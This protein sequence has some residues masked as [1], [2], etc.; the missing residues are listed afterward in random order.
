MPWTLTVRSG[1]QV[2]RLRF[3]DLGAALDVVHERVEELA[4]RAPSPPVA[5]GYRR[6]EPVER[7][8]ARVELSGPERRLGTVC[9]GIDVRG[10]GSAEAYMGR[11]R[12][13]RL[14]QFAGESAYDALRRA[15]MA[16]LDKAQ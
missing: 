14:E 8:A 4:D 5:A 10:D 11:V 9:A 2:Q 15:L 6:F 12:K 1:P 13:A 7:V 3:D 16:R